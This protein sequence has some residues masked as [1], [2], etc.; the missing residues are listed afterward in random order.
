MRTRAMAS[1]RRPVLMALPVTTGLRAAGFGW[2]SPVCVVY[3]DTCSSASPVSATAP[4]SSVSVDSATLSSS[5]FPLDCYCSALASALP[6]R[7]GLLDLL[8]LEGHRL[9]CL[10]GV[11]WAGV[12]L[13]L[14]QHL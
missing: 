3:S 4:A 14:A 8:D 6:S 10:V 7:A 1:L 5:Y 11:L 9:L 12:H 2:A 13:E